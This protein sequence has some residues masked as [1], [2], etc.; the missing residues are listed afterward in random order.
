MENP[1]DELLTPKPCHFSVIL[2][3]YRRVAIVGA[4]VAGRATARRLLAN[5]LDQ[6]ELIVLEA[7]KRGD[8]G[9]SRVGLSGIP[10]DLGAQYLTLQQPESDLASL[11]LQI[12]NGSF[13]AF[14]KSNNSYR[15]VHN[16]RVGSLIES[17]PSKNRER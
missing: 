10:S 15:V 11:P 7:S 3:M 4:G 17:D 1:N 6:H 12:W 5:G 13:G 2:Q 14:D 9:T 8:A 16:G